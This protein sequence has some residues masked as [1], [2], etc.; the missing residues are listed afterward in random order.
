MKLRTS[1]KLAALVLPL[2][3]LWTFIAC[4]SIC[5]DHSLDEAG[6]ETV[7]TQVVEIASAQEFACCPIEASPASLLPDRSSFSQRFCV[8]HSA[9]PVLT[10]ILQ[11]EIVP[12]PIPRGSDTIAGSP[13]LTQIC[14]L[15]I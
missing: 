6:C 5:T 12:D 13:P 1:K 7:F 15:R 2:T 9:T 11:A 8:S 14:V 4:V 10:T 3:F